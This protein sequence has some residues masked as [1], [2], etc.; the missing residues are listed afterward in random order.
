VIHSEN[1]LPVG[2]WFTGFRFTIYQ[3]Y[4]ERRNSPLFCF[5]SPNSIALQ[6][7]YIT[8]VEERLCCVSGVSQSSFLD[9]F[10]LTDGAS[11]EAI[12]THLLTN[13]DKLGFNKDVL[14]S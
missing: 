1:R 2:N 8:V 11:N 12:A 10:E 5:I 6:A 3:A 7:D 9:L 14:K 13:L 4:L